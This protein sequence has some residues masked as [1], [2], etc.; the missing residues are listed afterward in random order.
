MGSWYRFSFIVRLTIVTLIDRDVST[1]CRSSSGDSI[2]LLSRNICTAVV[3]SDWCITN[4]AHGWWVLIQSIVGIM[5]G[6]NWSAQRSAAVEIG[7]HVESDCRNPRLR[8]LNSTVPVDVVRVKSY[9]NNLLSST[10]VPVRVSVNKLNPERILPGLRSQVW[11]LIGVF[12]KGRS[13]G[14]WNL[15]SIQPLFENL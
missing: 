9:V 13:L 3:V 6:R 2:D 14:L 5:R 1:A 8:N 4:L 11:G 12:R 10:T 7:C 15:Y